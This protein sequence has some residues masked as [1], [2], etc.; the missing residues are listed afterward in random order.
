LWIKRA[1]RRVIVEKDARHFKIKLHPK[2][3][4]QSFENPQAHPKCISHM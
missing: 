2:N 3:A 4:W 1:Q